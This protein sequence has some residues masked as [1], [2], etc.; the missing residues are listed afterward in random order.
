MSAELVWKIG[1]L[2]VKPKDGAHTD[3]VVSCDWSCTASENGKDAII[4]GV[5]QFEKPGNPFIKF[6]NLKEKDVLQWCWDNGVDKS[7]MENKAILALQNA[8]SAPVT[9]RMSPWAVAE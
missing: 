2:S 9:N 6:E 7:A 8:M 4:S 5:K 1:L 3:V